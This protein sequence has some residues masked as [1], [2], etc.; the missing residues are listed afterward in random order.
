MFGKRKQPPIRSLIA[1]GT[2]IT[3]DLSFSEGLRVD[4]EIRGNVQAVSGPP[5]MLVISE[6]ALIQGE[7]RA[8]LIVANGTVQGPVFAGDLLELQPKAR[9]EG[10][11]A[12][13]ALE[14]H[15]GAT[16]TGKLQPTVASAQEPGGAEKPP[17]T[18]AASNG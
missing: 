15:Q 12:Y 5:S 6:T 16:I 11:V 18:L 14:M 1:Q 10:D 3:G 2:V 8:D 9:I 13:A 7:V 4:G 17:L